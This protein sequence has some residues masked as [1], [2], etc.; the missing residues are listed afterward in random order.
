[1]EINKVVIEVIPEAFADLE[2]GAS[3]LWLWPYEYIAD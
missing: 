1:M 3:A 2:L